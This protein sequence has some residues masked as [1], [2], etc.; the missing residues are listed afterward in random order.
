MQGTSGCIRG[1]VR[2]FFSLYVSGF[3]FSIRR[4]DEGRKKGLNRKRQ[5][6]LALKLNE[7]GK[8]ESKWQSCKL[9]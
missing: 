4:I 1:V 9:E 6:D 3:D 7:L 2:S 8:G 5:A